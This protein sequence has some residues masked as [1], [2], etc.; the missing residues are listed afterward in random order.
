MYNKIIIEFLSALQQNNNREWFEVNKAKYQAALAQVTQFGDRLISAIAK[1][2]SS[3]AELKAKDCI[4]RIYRDVRFSKNKEPYKDHFG[5]YFAPGG[6][7]SKLAGYYVHI[8]PGG[9]SFV[10]GGIYAPEKEELAAIRQ[11]IFYNLKDYLAI[12]DK[13]E[14]KA[15]FPE[16]YGEQLKTAPKGF[17]KDDPA[18]PYI[19]NKHFAV[20][21]EVDDAFW[22]NPDLEKNLMKIFKLQKSFNDFLN[23]AVKNLE[24]RD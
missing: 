14:F 24:M 22:T 23:E 10:G 8:Q 6:R 20:V 15:V 11:E 7:K 3:V 5:A 1:I 17:D 19:R 4:F 2:D 12:I 21:H 13:K 16:I 9:H 18:I